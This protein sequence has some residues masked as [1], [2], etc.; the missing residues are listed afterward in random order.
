[1]EFFRSAAGKGYNFLQELD[2]GA[3]GG[4]TGSDATRTES[5]DGVPEHNKLFGGALAGFLAPEA[6]AGDEAGSI[7]KAASGLAS[8]FGRQLLS[9]LND[10]GASASAVASGGD[11]REVDQRDACLDDGAGCGGS[12]EPPALGIGD[13][14]LRNGAGPAQCTEQDTASAE[15]ERPGHPSEALVSP[16]PEAP[17]ERQRQDAE[18]VAGEASAEDIVEAAS[19]VAGPAAEAMAAN[20]SLPTEQHFIGDSDGDDD[21]DD[22]VMRPQLE[23]C[24]PTEW[25]VPSPEV[26]EVAQSAPPGDVSA[27]IPAVASAQTEDLSVASSGL[28]P[29][30]LQRLTEALAVARTELAL[31]ARG[32]EATEKRLLQ[33]NKDL[34]REL[35]EAQER[36]QEQIRAADIRA[37]SAG[38]NE[39]DQV[40]EWQKRVRAVEGERDKASSTLQRSLAAEKRLLE[41]NKDMEK[42]L[43][44]AQENWTGQIKKALQQEREAV[45]ECERLRA[46]LSIRE[47][48]SGKASAGEGDL[49]RKVEAEFATLCG[50]CER[51]LEQL[52][53]AAEVEAQLRRELSAMDHTRLQLE[54][55]AASL[56]V[57]L[58]RAQAAYAEA[59]QEVG[60]MA[61]RLDELEYGSQS[62]VGAEELMRGE[63]TAAKERA[64]ELER[65]LNEV[66]WMRDYALQQAE[67]A[68]AQ[69]QKQ[70]EE[71][72]KLEAERISAADAAAADAEVAAAS[73]ATSATAATA[74]VAAPSAIPPAG[75]NSTGSVSSLDLDAKLVS[76]R[77]EH[78]EDLKRLAQGHREELEYLRR[79]SDEKD[80]RL[81]TL[82]CD[83]NALRLENTEQGATT[84]ATKGKVKDAETPDLE[85]GLSFRSSSGGGGGGCREAVADCGRDGDIVLRRFSRVLFVSRTMRGVFFGYMLMLHIWIWVVLHHTAASR[86]SGTS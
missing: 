84:S 14:P 38:K 6:G 16:E 45:A 8:G 7:W 75:T 53:A 63:L 41:E 62:K 30:E 83:R 56:T 24:D 74:S 58:E 86:T 59:V 48:E 9:E 22:A 28:L 82:I 5:G 42:E 15:Q 21:D 43:Y 27:E 34:E 36:W 35:Q 25:R 85:E 71:S 4:S 46:E 67:E 65:Q 29:T 47:E 66:T 73:A 76:L 70:R 50:E 33:E 1:M 18:E 17:A 54:D 64:A 37:E 72:A 79:R 57:Q 49:R 31:Q 2:D 23:T 32:R 77:V 11:A 19:V 69:A 39:S 3:A 44:A 12:A 26:S 10:G 20:A 81:E 80:R 68:R 78:G 40:K 55:Q 61:A 60:S 13:E 51:L 52:R